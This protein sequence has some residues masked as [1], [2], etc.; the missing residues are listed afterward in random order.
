MKWP[1]LTAYGFN[2]IVMQRL[3]NEGRAFKVIVAPVDNQPLQNAITSKLRRVGFEKN[4]S[5]A[6]IVELEKFDQ[7][8]LIKEFPA[9]KYELV[10]RNELIITIDHRTSAPD[11]EPPLSQEES[12]HAIASVTGVRG[13]DPGR[14]SD[15]QPTLPATSPSGDDEPENGLSQPV[16]R[17]ADGGSVVIVDGAGSNQDGGSDQRIEAGMGVEQ[18]Q[19]ES[20][21]HTGEHPSDESDG[22]VSAGSPADNQGERDGVG[23]LPSAPERVSVAQAPASFNPNHFYLGDLL[24]QEFESSFSKNERFDANMAAI[25][26]VGSREFGASNKND[27]TNEEKA[28]LAK[29]VGWGGLSEI[30]SGVTSSSSYGSSQYKSHREQVQK[31]LVLGNINEDD[32][33]SFRRSSLNAHYTSAE[34]IRAIWQIVA[35][36]GFTGGKVLESSLGI[37]NFLG[38]MPK[39]IVESSQIYGV[40]KDRLSA[41][42]AKAIYPDAAIEHMGFEDYKMPQGFFDL[43]IGNVPFGNFSVSD[44]DY[45]QYR[46][47][48]H[49]Y[50]LVKNLDLL[51][52][53]GIAALMTSTHTLDAKN[54]ATRRL[55]ASK[56][57]FLGAIRLPMDAFAKNAATGVATDILFFRREDRPEMM[58]LPDEELPLWARRIG[59]VGS[60]LDEGNEEGE[61]SDDYGVPDRKD[62]GPAPYNPWF[63]ENPTCVV[64]ELREVST[65]FGYAIYPEL[66][67]KDAM[68]GLLRAAGEAIAKEGLYIPRQSNGLKLEQEFTPPRLI[69]GARVNNFTVGSL[70]IEDD[71]IMCVDSISSDGQKA[72]MSDYVHTG[73]RSE[74]E[75]IKQ[76]IELRDQV[77][78]VINAQFSSDVG[79]D[80]V[81]MTEERDQLNFLYDS[82]VSEHGFVNDRRNKRLLASDPRANLLFAIE[83]YDAETKTAEKG[84]IFSQRI[85]SKPK[86]PESAA[87]PDEALKIVL[88]F[89]GD[90]NQSLIL[91]LLGRDPL[92][93]DAWYEVA[94]DLNDKKLIFQ[95]PIDEAW[96]IAERYL[97]GNLYEKLDVAIRAAKNDPRYLINEQAIKE[98]LPAPLPPEEIPFSLSATWIEKQ[99]IERF[100]AHVFKTDVTRL[101]E[102]ITYDYEPVTNSTAIKVVES[103]RSWLLPGNSEQFDLTNMAGKG[104]HFIKFLDAAINRSNL[105]VRRKHTEGGV[106]FIDLEAT[107]MANTK[108]AEVEREFRNWLVGD[109]E[110]SVKYADKYNRTFNGYVRSRSSGDHLVFPGMNPLVEMR[111]HQKDAI[112]FTVVNGDSIYA[113]EVGTGKTYTLSGAAMTLSQMERIKRPF[114]VVKNSTLDQ[115]AASARYLY[116]GAEIITV[117]Q[118]N[119]SKETRQKFLAGLA[120]SNFDLAIMSYETFQS[121]GLKPGTQMAYIEERLDELRVALES[122]TDENQGNRKKSF[123]MKQIEAAISRLESRLDKLAEKMRQGNDQVVTLEEIM[124]GAI[125]FDEMHTL[126]NVTSTSKNAA[127][128]VN[129][130]LRADMALLSTQVLKKRNPQTITVGA[131]GTPISNAFTEA[132]VLM[133]FMIPEVLADMT[134]SSNLTDMDRFAGHFVSLETQVEMKVDG[135]YGDKTRVGVRDLPRLMDAMGL[136]MDVRFASDLGLERPEP[137]RIKVVVEPSEVQQIYRFEIMDR[138]EEIKRGDVDPKVDNYLKLASDGRKS[139]IDMRL[140]DPRI[141]FDP[142]GKV[143]T[144][145]NLLCEGYAETAEIAGTQ[146]VFLDQGVPGGVAF[147]LYQDIKDRLIERGIPADEIAFAHDAKTDAQRA[148]LFAKVNSGKIRIIIGSTEKMGVGVNMQERLAR[149]YHVDAPSNMRPADVEQREGRILRQGNMN[150]NIKIYTMTTKDSFDVFIWQLMAAKHKMIEAVMRGDRSI[151]AM[152]EDDPASYEAIIAAT[153]GNKSIAEKIEAEREL[154]MIKGALRD[155][156]NRMNKAR[157]AIN[158]QRGNIREMGKMIVFH[159]DLLSRIEDWKHEFGLDGDID[160]DGFVVIDPSGGEE[161][162]KSK[163][164]KVSVWADSKGEAINDPAEYFKEIRKEFKATVEGKRSAYSGGRQV[165]TALFYCGMPVEWTLEARPDYL[166]G[167]NIVSE[168]SV[169]RLETGAVSARQLGA[170]ATSLA[171]ISDERARCQSRLLAS[172]E[173]L[174]GLDETLSKGQ[175]VVDELQLRHGKAMTRLSLAIEA[176]SAEA[177]RIKDSRKGMATLTVRDWIAQNVAGAK[178]VRQILIDG[179]ISRV[180]NEPEQATFHAYACDKDSLDEQHDNDIGGDSSPR[181]EKGGRLGAH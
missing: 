81:L 60:L 103:R 133:Q 79:D 5:G 72:W 154:S 126:K 120:V 122:A 84:H 125:F 104:W 100:I 40:E 139:A 47:S 16:P 94:Q 73:P 156:D 160:G 9:L 78:V 44:P 98:R 11:R 180:I 87:T 46:L 96:V 7:Q 97:S 33:K 83:K 49:N 28:V 10:P 127:L 141:P 50:F 80:D 68:P 130:S 144:L 66:D 117:S 174:I 91:S 150:K 175:S 61:E 131:T 136:F 95:N 140:V 34:V 90:I 26:L 165:D 149:L 35:Q 56:G 12:N 116:P 77:V 143:A 29:Y 105:T 36:S 158:W 169:L 168:S 43:A 129:G 39:P 76:M 106:P 2:L 30:L 19:S 177:E 14:E 101:S 27:F 85:L 135:T 69:H 124:P 176:A 102:W 21:G 53:G 107:M 162:G 23:S 6:F 88:G 179:G 137:D 48:I 31:Q 67:D 24:D 15:L 172:E 152:T 166:S 112:W 163:R 55:L 113:H 111:P 13:D 181:A 142:N 148:A 115:F 54:N 65:Q 119:L 159:D 110:L 20:T 92:D 57:E 52:E 161:G 4:S 58:R 114:L 134:G 74:I 89:T 121:I 51:R 3:T 153:T 86:M 38:L 62:N 147:N 171:G 167:K 63:D 145:I 99:D 118:E 17:N 59:G 157:S 25:S 42:I 164:N 64:G 108:V 22:L 18:P 155:Q 123:S 93:A 71:K 151:E 37:G 170:L 132:K 75:R 173:Q 70:V 1:K 32:L 128:A 109:D 178:G 8:S 41:Q 82:F 146:A 138:A 45:N